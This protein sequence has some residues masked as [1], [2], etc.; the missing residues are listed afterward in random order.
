MKKI[1]SCMLYSFVILSCVFSLVSCKNSNVTLKLKDTATLE[2][3]SVFNSSTSGYITPEGFDWDKLEKKGYTM[4]ITV[5]YDVYYEKNW[6]DLG[7]V[8]SPKYEI[9]IK[10]SDGMGQSDSNMTT[11]TTAKTRS[12]S[13]SCR[14]V[15][16]KNTSI[17]LEVSSNNIQNI[18]HFKNVKINY[19]CYK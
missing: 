2:D 18:I 9:S 13:F 12:I 17:I 5:N 10:T 16:L 6:G 15:D 8:G 1:I 11:S 7:Y 3:F 4:K 19:T 14:A